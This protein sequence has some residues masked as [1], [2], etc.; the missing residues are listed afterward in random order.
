MKKIDHIGIA[1]KDLKKSN[2]I[3][4]KILGEPHY[5]QEI[6]EQEGVVTSFFQIGESRIE[7]LSSTEEG[8]PI[9]KY[10]NR[11]SEGIHHIS[12]EVEDIY[13]EIK[14]L[15]NEGFSFIEP[16]IRDGADNKR[17]AFLHPKEANGI[18]IE[19][20]QKK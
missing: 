4:R 8:S 2:N 5:K 1:V 13:L 12:F 11:N 18:L 16:K 10:L 15:E 20:S 17:I 3:F 19:L 9:D 7:L 6:I 14:R